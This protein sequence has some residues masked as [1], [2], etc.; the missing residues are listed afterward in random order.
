[1]GSSR[2]DF[3]VEDGIAA[4]VDTAAI[5]RVVVLQIEDEM[6]RGHVSKAALARR[7]RT[8]RVAVDRLLDTASGAMILVAGVVPGWKGWVSTGHSTAS[9]SPSSHPVPFFELTQRV[10]AEHAR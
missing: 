6:K 10:S 1:V 4:E 7:M 3:L 2:D 9:F 8:S 5:K